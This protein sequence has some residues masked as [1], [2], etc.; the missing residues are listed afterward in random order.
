MFYIIIL[1]PSKNFYRDK[2]YNLAHNV[3]SKQLNFFM[4][5][6]VIKRSTF[7]KG[8]SKVMDVNFYDFFLMK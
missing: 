2:L 5:N 1:F 8:R 7:Y 4:K 6:F 3:Y